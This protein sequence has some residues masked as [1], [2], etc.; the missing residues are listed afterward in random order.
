M[1]KSVV[2]LYTNNKQPEKAIP[3]TVASK[4]IKYL[5]IHLNKETKDML[6]AT[7]HMKESNTNK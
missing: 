5:R 7:K 6:K 4:R 1:Q 3:F 2:F